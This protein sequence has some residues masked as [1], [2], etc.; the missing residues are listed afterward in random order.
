MPPTKLAAEGLKAPGPKK[1]KLGAQKLGITKKGAAGAAGG[2]EGL[3]S[4]W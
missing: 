4:D 2:F 3:G 1:G